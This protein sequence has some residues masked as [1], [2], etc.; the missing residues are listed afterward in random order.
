M[1]GILPVRFPFAPR[2]LCTALTVALVGGLACGEK[3][4]GAPPQASAEIKRRFAPVRWDTLWTRGG[5]EA[6]TFL[7]YPVGPMAADQKHVYVADAAAFRVVAFRTADGSTA[8]TAGR[9][10]SGP[11]EFLSLTAMA[12]EPSGTLLVAD[13]QNGRLAV[14]A[15]DGTILRHVP[16]R[17][18]SYVQSLCALMDGPT[19]LATL[20]ADAPIVLVAPDGALVRRVPLPWPDLEEHAPLSR[21]AYLASGGTHQSCVLALILGRGFSIFRDG[22]FDQGHPYVEAFDLPEVEVS[23][24]KQGQTTRRQQQLRNR[25][26]AAL[27][28]AGDS[29]TFAV[30]FQG[31]TNHAG[32]LIDVYDI[33]TGEYLHSYVFTRPVHELARAGGLYFVLQEHDGYRQLLAMRAATDGGPQAP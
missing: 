25:R 1:G 15:A 5:T 16:L 17:H 8:W 33:D 3:T 11:A 6:D 12:V 29:A 20:D 21:Q 24:S 32:R 18:V 2:L 31:E 27:A 7:L 30:V 9:R 28:V 19:L 10:G 22:R 14:V 13:P 23:V 4:G 26:I